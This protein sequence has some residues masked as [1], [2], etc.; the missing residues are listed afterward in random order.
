MTG[1]CASVCARPEESI[2]T[3]VGSEEA[4]TAAAR[5][6]VSPLLNTPVAVKGSLIPNGTKALS[7]VT[8]IDSN[9][10]AVTCRLALPEID[11]T[12][13][14]TVTMPMASPVASPLLS[15]EAID[16]GADQLTNC[17]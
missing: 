2:E 16:P 10:G 7:G 9:V 17:V 5:S 12:D 3:D 1:P 6:C 4:H 8:R 11:P 15:I 14:V 13:A